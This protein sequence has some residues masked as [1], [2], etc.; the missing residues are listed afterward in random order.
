M[1]IAY[2]SPLPPA[3]SGIA[4]YS[5]ELLPHLAEYADITLFF[6]P[7]R[8]PA[9][10]LAEAFPTDEIEHFPDRRQ[11]FDVALYHMGNA[12][13]YHEAIW[14]TLQAYPG[15]IVAHDTVFYHFFQE[16]TRIRD[17]L[18]GFQAILQETYGARAAQRVMDHFNDGIVNPVTFPLVERVLD[19]ALGTIVH[20]RYA[21]RQVA[22][23][24]PD[25]PVAVVP[26]HL[27][28]PAPFDKLRTQ[29][30]DG[31]VD[32]EAIRREL[33][34]AGHFVV[35]TFGFLTP[36]KRIPVALRGFAR[37]RENHPEAI[38]CLVG[39][40]RLDRALDEL[41]H[42]ARLPRET[43]RVTGRVLLDE[44]LNYMAAA[45]VAI[46]LRY[47]TA[48]ETSGTLIRLLGLGVPTIVSHS[49]SFAELPDDVCAKLPVDGFEEDVLVTILRALADD[50]DLR[51]A[52]AANAHDYVREHHTLKG[53]AEAYVTF[54]ERI[55]AGEAESA[56]S[57]G[58]S[59][60]TEAWSE[61]GRTLAGWGVTEHDDALL[62]PIAQALA[63]L[64]IGPER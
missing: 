10:W 56:R 16:L 49:G 27:S 5:A 29:P 39:E 58:D 44:F 21:A 8:P 31:A 17:G 9:P 50:E 57:A 25:V 24:C 53:S 3:Q 34:L 12:G 7:R 33:G 46:N 55:V 32:R 22:E 20:S 28:L 14:R 4:D 47:P 23:R 41:V 63:Q 45:D 51:R 15:V 35:G 64:Q 26:H 62:E 13:R 42:E 43:V 52:M 18:A 11:E 60:L 19:G 30:F 54:M 48:G 2:F 6:D 61:I 36:W 1:R 59:P 37:F 38:Y 40:V